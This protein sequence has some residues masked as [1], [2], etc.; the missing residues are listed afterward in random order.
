MSPFLL[1]FPLKSRLFQRPPKESIMAAV[2][3]ELDSIMRHPISFL[4]HFIQATII[5][6]LPSIFWLFRDEF[7]CLLEIQIAWVMLM[8]CPDSQDQSFVE[9]WEVLQQQ[10]RKHNFLDRFSFII[11][12]NHWKYFLLCFIFQ[13]LGK[14]RPLVSLITCTCTEEI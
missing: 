3:P 6:A 2:S 9:K 12:K 10:Y 8:S 4:V 11:I 1:P 14:Q 7:M 5:A 13:N